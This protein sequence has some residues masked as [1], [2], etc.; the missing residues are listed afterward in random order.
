MEVGGIERLL[1]GVMYPE[2]GIIRRRV[3]VTR[4]AAHRHVA[5]RVKPQEAVLEPSL[6]FVLEELDT[7]GRLAHGD[8]EQVLGSQPRRRS[9]C[10]EVAREAPRV[11]LEH[12]GDSFLPVHC[13]EQGSYIDGHAAATVSVILYLGI[14]LR[15]ALYPLTS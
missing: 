2:G 3:E 12:L 11:V 10:A 14:A 5:R 9:V 1:T 8:V 7:P 6:E 15:R 4:L 13:R